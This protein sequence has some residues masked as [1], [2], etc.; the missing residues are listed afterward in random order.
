MSEQTLPLRQ[1]VNINDTWDLTPLFQSQSDWETLYSEVEGKL[2][3]FEAFKGKL[4]DSFEIFKKAIESDYSI[5]RKLETIYTYAHLKNDEDKTNQENAALYQRAMNLYTRFSEATSFITPEIQSIPDETMN[6]FI[7]TPEITEYRFPLEQ[8]LRSKAHTRS[9]EVEQILAMASEVTQAPRQIFSQLDNADLTFGNIDDEDGNTVELSHG[10]FVSFLTSQNDTLRKKAFDQYYQVYDDHKY[11]IAATLASSIKKDCFFSKVKHFESCR[12]ASLFADNVDI[13]VYDNLIDTIK[14]NTAPLFQYF[15]FRKKVLNLEELHFYDTY[16]P[17]V[18]EVDFKMSYDEAVE[19]CLKAVEP[20]GKEYVDLLE[21][22][23]KS[24]WV[25]KYENK[26]KRSGAYSSGCYDSPPYMLM[27][28]NENTINSLFTLIHEAGHSMHSLYSCNH[29]P[30]ATHNYTIFVAEVAS[31]LNETLLSNYLLKKY[32][33]D[34]KMK[35]Y[36]INREIDNI[37]GTMFRQTMFAEFEKVTHARAEANEP[38]TL[39][40]FT[41]EYKKLL[42]AYFG[43]TIVIDDALCLECLRIPH[44][45]SPF[46]VYKYA[47]G[48]A[49]AIAICDRIITKGAPAVEDYLNFLKMGGSD[50]PINELKTA[51]VDMN[52]PEPVENAIKHF[53]KLVNQLEEVM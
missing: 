19:T 11:S 50:F 22:G 31:T 40:T 38:L 44:F 18:K 39:E 9:M 49:A 1:D 10:N 37:R 27:N 42:E 17:V 14:N 51:G 52:S 13:S 25:D 35:A 8:I 53:A 7:N 5:S 33:N 3:E 12:K 16:V 32:S 47:T 45:Y 24:G 20:L 6:A 34:P 46:Y 29:Q 41:T 21:K 2:P 36:L 28:Y 48:L 26:G 30:Y 43:D 23:F 4:G 15:R